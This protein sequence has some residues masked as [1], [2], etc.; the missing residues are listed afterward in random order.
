MTQ[1]FAGLCASVLGASMCSASIHSLQSDWSDVSNPNGP[2]S[3]REGNNPLPHVSDWHL[4]PWGTPQPGWARS[5]NAGIGLPVFLKSNGTE[6]F[7]H[8]WAADQIVVHSTDA[9]NGV[10]SGPANIL[11]TVPEAGT[12]SVNGGVWIGRDIGRGVD[13]SIFLN[14]TLLTHG[15]VV[16]GDPFSSSTPL[17]FSAGSGGAGAVAGLNVSTNDLLMLRF[18][19][20]NSGGGDFVGIDLGV[21]IV[22]TPATGA[23]MGIGAIAFARRRR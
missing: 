19:S 9:V 3:L 8:D 4:S 12:L 16:S 20:Q 17:S 14:G 1:F 7:G 5:G 11:F 6:A 15:S 10:G 22:P 2:W 23:L 21:Y 13:W 18:D